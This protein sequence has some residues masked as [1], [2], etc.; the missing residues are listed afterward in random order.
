MPEAERFVVV[1]AG[2]GQ[3]LGR[4]GDN[5]GGDRGREMILSMITNSLIGE[6]HETK[7][8]TRG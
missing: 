7:S 5:S 3:W 8:N 2:W 4:D 1:V 6:Y